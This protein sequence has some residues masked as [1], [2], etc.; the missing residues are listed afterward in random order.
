MKQFIKK[1]IFVGMGLVLPLCTYAHALNG[2]YGVAGVGIGFSTATSKPFQE[3]HFVSIPNYPTALILANGVTHLVDG[4]GLSGDVGLGIRVGHFGLEADY[5]SLPDYIEL[6]TATASNN[7]VSFGSFTSSDKISLNV[8]QLL[9]SIYFK[10]YHKLDLRLGTGLAI[11]DKFA[12][13]RT[14]TFLILNGSNINTSPN[15]ANT[16]Y[17]PEVMV[18]LSEKIGSN[19]QG[20]IIYNYI[21]GEH[22]IAINNAAKNFLPT[23]Q[24]LRFDLSYFFRT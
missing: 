1:S 2:F 11:V 4:A 19:I 20:S 13:K 18:G 9:G 22:T 24:S 3:T 21:F 8:Y 15:V 7:L 23:L 17:Q 16:F 5:L 10:I 6:T 14:N 12:H